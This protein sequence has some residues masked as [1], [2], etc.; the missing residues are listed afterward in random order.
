[1]K[2]VEISVQNQRMSGLRDEKSS[3]TSDFAVKIAEIFSAKVFQ[4]C[5][6]GVKCD[7]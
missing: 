7:F 3:G 6:S 4:G 2:T 1:M 5:L